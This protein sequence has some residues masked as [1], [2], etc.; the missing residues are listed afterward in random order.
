L[1]VEFHGIRLVGVSGAPSG[2]KDDRCA[3]MGIDA[4]TMDLEL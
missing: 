1:A 2:A 3:R 4:I